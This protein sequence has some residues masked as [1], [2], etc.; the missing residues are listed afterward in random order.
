M[1]RLFLVLLVINVLFFLWWQL[2]TSDDQV[3]RQSQTISDSTQS[4][5]LLSEADKAKAS[6]QGEINQESSK[7]SET[8]SDTITSKIKEVVIYSDTSLPVN[9]DVLVADQNMCYKLGP[10]AE[11][12]KA[13]KVMNELM[14]LGIKV[15]QRTISEPVHIGYR[16]YIPPLP[17]KAEAREMLQGLKM[18]NINDSAIIRQGE[19]ENAIS[20]GVFSIQSGAKRH[21]KAM[22]QKGFS[23]KIADRYRDSDQYWLNAYDIDKTDRL[24]PE[25]ARLFKKSPEIKKQVINCK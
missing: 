24:S 13:K 7:S 15:N 1:K 25:W 11:K 4:L 3:M 12:N 10:F 21:Q 19:Y 20:L 2:G 8:A 6:Q 14:Y 17:S 16:V 9:N 22:T 23:V 5:V 18:Q